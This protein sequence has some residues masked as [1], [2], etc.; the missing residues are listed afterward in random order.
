MSILSR[1]KLRAA[2]IGELQHILDDGIAEQINSGFELFDTG[3]LDSVGLV[4]LL[5]AVEARLETEFQ[6]EDLDFEA[7]DTIG[8]LVEQLHGLQQD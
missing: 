6:L 5:Q 8:S 7:L 3:R 1:E 4:R 2:V